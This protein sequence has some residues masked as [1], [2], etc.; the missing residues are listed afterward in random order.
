MSDLLGSAN[1][2]T[3]PGHWRG[4]QLGKAGTPLD[5][6]FL[7]LGESQQLL[8]NLHVRAPRQHMISVAATRSGK[9]VSLIIP[10]LLNYAGA[11]LVVDPK[12]ENAWVTA[13]YRRNVLNQHT[14]ILDPWEEV[15]HAYGSL[16]GVEEQC[17]SFNPLSILDPDSDNFAED[18][19]Y[20]ADALILT[21]STKEPYFDNTAR[22]LWAGLMAFVVENPE[23]SNNATLEAARKLL[24]QSN[25]EL[26]LTIRAAIGLGPDTVA[27]RKLAQFENFKDTTSIMSVISSART[28][29]SFLDSDALNRSMEKSDFSFDEL[30][31][32][33]VSI[34]L[35]LPVERLQTHARWLR[36]MVSI[37]IRAIARGRATASSHGLPALF[38]LDEFG[39]I[40]KL[41]AVAQ[42]FGLMAGLGMIMWGFVQDFNQLKRDYPTHWGTFI[43]NSQAVTCFAVLDNFTTEYI[44]KNLGIQTI[45]EP[46]TQTQVSSTKAPRGQGQGLFSSG[47]SHTSGTTTSMHTL[48]RPLMNP[49]EIARLPGD[50]CI[51]MGHFPPIRSRRM[52]YHEDWWFLHRARSD[53]HH[54]ITD[55]VRAQALERRLRDAG[56]VTGL[57]AQEG[58]EVKPVRGGCYEM[59]GTGGAAK[60][61]RTFAT[62]NDLWK[63]A[64][65]LVMD[66]VDIAI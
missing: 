37:G 18:L 34:Y 47:T 50:E 38:M 51:I 30:C 36:L 41:D 25:S 26:Q 58:Y 28:Q 14:I 24:M 59:R 3:D 44:S 20:L 11:V 55:G 57:L 32:G 56:S 48:S 35:V 7:L 49:D 8:G 60:G 43:A 33:N 39:T 16:A 63:W 23:Y 40:G 12:G 13:P 15:N 5:G 4:E 6:H 19:A 29:T 1:W 65:V 62:A 54:P 66:G 21:E 42:A 17:A 27:A 31:R 52:V 53:P 22:E 45:Q 46:Q 10:N 61:V 64:Y 9:G 2:S